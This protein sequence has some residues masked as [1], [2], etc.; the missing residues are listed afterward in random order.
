MG[1]M[2]SPAPMPHGTSSAPT[3]RSHGDRARVGSWNQEPQGLAFLC[4]H[5]DPLLREGV[6][7][8]SRS[9]PLAADWS[10]SFLKA[11]IAAWLLK[12]SQKRWVNSVAPS[13]VILNQTA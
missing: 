13:N 5:S 2:L 7:T 12:H 9:Q 3:A 8:E 11:M 4:P 10:L 6:K 1:W